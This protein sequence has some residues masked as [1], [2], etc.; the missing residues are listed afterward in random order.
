MDD[1]T[2]RGSGIKNPKVRQGPHQCLTRR[3]NVIEDHRRTRAQ[4]VTVGQADVYRAVAVPD[5]VQNLVGSPRQSCDLG[6][7]LLAF[8]VGPQQDR[9][10]N[11]LVDPTGDDG[12]G[13]GMRRRDR[14]Q[15]RQFGVA[16]Q[17][18][19]N[20]R[21]PVETSARNAANNGALTA[22]PG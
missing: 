11:V 12:R 17:M 14:K 13:R 18:G 21:Q 6:H 4:R 22:S 10:R 3:S 9:I 16:V 2:D 1:N 20:G 15:P 19:V 5:L 7:P 8:T